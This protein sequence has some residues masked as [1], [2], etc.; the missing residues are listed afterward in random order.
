MFGVP[1]PL[2]APAV[3]G[4][5]GGEPAPKKGRLGLVV[6]VVVGL[7]A[8]LGLAAAAVAIVPRL[9]S[10]GA[11]TASKA[12]GPSE[13]D[14]SSEAQGPPKKAKNPAPK[15]SVDPAADE[16]TAKPAASSAA[17]APSVS[18]APSASASALPSASASATAPTAAPAGDGDV[19]LEITCSPPCDAIT[20]DGAP[21]KSPVTV[22]AGKHV[23][24]GSK[25]GYESQGKVLEAKAGTTHKIYFPLAKSGG[26]KDCGKF[27]KRCD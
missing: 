14:E 16:P 4:I 21:A 2:P 22:T 26:K 20:V 1:T 25:K 8:L 19:V 6:G 12:S 27:L 17:P 10:G 24:V 9:T 23:L 13:G 18:A 15:P 3:I 11:K 7:F 5:G